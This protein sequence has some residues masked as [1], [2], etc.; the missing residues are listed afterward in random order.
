MPGPGAPPP[1]YQQYPG[2]YQ[3]PQTEGMA[4]AALVLAICSFVFFQPITAI[5]AL[6][7]S[8]SSDRK[9]AESG[10]RLTGE[11]FNKVARIVSW[12]NIGLCAL[13]AVFIIVIIIVAVATSD[14]A[15]ALALAGLQA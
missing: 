1:P 9:I 4:I 7:L 10:G 2:G 13:I 14:S 8:S 6:V 12:I 15:S 11:T 5:I 3:P